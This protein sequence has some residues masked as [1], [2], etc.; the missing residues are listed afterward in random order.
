MR[1]V[2]LIDVSRANYIRTISEFNKSCL[3]YFYGVTVYACT[4]VCVCRVLC[5]CVCVCVCVCV[6]A[7]VRVC[8]CESDRRARFRMDTEGKD[9]VRLNKV[10]FFTLF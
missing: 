9:T 3:I 1:L 2:M 6:C 10:I 5:G 7:C 8:V 4:R